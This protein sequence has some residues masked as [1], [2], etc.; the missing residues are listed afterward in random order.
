MTIEESAWNFNLGEGVDKLTEK[1]HFREAGINAC[2]VIHMWIEMVI[3]QAKR[4]EDPHEE[5]KRWLKESNRTGMLFSNR[6]MNDDI[7]EAVKLRVLGEEEAKL[8]KRILHY[9]DTEGPGHD[10][11]QRFNLDLISNKEKR[12]KF[13]DYINDCRTLWHV[14]RKKYNEL[15][16]EVT[17]R[18]FPQFYED[19]KK[20]NN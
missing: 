4:V 1:G 12:R 16:L 14:L 7:K 8:A 11:R 19:E 10:P 2:D 6:K 20:M 15:H 18:H 9:R 17:R 5:L 13:D 3:M